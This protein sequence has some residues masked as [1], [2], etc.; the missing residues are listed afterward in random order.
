LLPGGAQRQIVLV[1]ER[2]QG[3]RDGHEFETEALSLRGEGPR[4]LSLRSVYVYHHT[5]DPIPR[6]TYRESMTS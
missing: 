1:P 5:R 3:G 2:F 6:A 4:Q